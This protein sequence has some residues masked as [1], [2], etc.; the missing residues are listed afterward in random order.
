MNLDITEIVDKLIGRAEWAGESHSD[1]EAL[2]NLREID[3]LLED[4]LKHL[5]SNVEAM[6][7]HPGNYSAEKLGT[8]S[9]EI[10]LNI[11]SE[12]TRLGL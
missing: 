10:L 4:M 11:K 8:A 2:E 9:K 5:I 12:I 7:Q 6:E 1:S 3:Y